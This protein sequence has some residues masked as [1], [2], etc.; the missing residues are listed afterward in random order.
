MPTSSRCAPR[1]R[2]AREL[3]ASRLQEAERGSLVLEDRPHERLRLAVATHAVGLLGELAEQ[4]VHV[5]LG[6]EALEL[7]R[8]ALLGGD[9]HVVE[10]LLRGLGELGA[11]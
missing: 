7:L 11:R 9:E 10:E 6:E 8:V 2:S 4:R 5:H 1:T 3:L